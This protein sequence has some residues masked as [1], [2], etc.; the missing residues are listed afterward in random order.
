MPSVFFVVCVCVCSQAETAAKVEKQ[1]P[2][3]VV[4]GKVDRKKLS[5]I[6]VGNKDRIEELQELVHPLGKF[7]RE[8]REID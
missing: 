7:F 8:R 4:D 6:V 2:G 3:S 5:E 1:F